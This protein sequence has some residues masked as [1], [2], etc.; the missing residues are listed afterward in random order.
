[1]TVSFLTTM[2]STLHRARFDAHRD[3]DTTSLTSFLCL[4]EDVFE[5]VK[6]LVDGIFEGFNATIFAYGQTST[7]KSY[8]MGTGQVRV[9][10][11]C[12][13][14]EYLCT[15]RGHVS[16]QHLCRELRRRVLCRA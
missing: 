4:Q 1:M 14:A 9:R 11:L 15:K 13:V 3:D 6:P 10:V 16:S 5:I 2:P 8:T 7:G 12:F